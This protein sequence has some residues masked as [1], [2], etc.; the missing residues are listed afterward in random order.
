MT[1]K[2]S[3]KN[4][5]E[6]VSEERRI[7]RELVSL[8]NSLKR[9][10]NTEEANL[11]ISQINSLKISIKNIEKDIAKTLELLLMAKPLRTDNFGGVEEERGKEVR[12]LIQTKF[13]MEK[14]NLL[15]IEKET[16]TRLRGGKKNLVSK[17]V[18]KPSKYVKISNDFFA[19]FSEK[20][21]TRDAFKNLK[22][23]LIKAN[24]QLVPKSYVSLILSTTVLSLIISLFILLFF[25]FFGLGATPPFI[26]QASGS[27]IKRFATIFWIVLVI[28]FFTFI[29]MY[30][31][32][33]MEKKSIANKI[34]REL[35]FATIHM[36]AI[37]GSMIDPSKIF[38]IIIMTGEYKNIEKEFTKIIN[39]INIYG[40]DLVTAL[41]HVSINTSSKRLAE[42][43]NGLTTT[44]TSGG[45][46]PDFFDKRSESLLF[47]YR[48]EEEKQTKA[49]ETFMD[50]YI[51]LVIAAPMILMLLLMMMNISGMGL[52]LDKNA[53]TLIMVLGVTVINFFSLTFLHLKQPSK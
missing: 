40:Y 29:F 51:S 24:I 52:S 15:E 1:G 32:P 10:N 11:I 49:A 39:E 17:K 50:I 46:L 2:D 45:N 30:F 14:L 28:P 13:S 20:L 25:L 18:K 21:I 35:P 5:K 16:L 37:A 8:L 44:I 4:L 47:S 23:D 9:V 36:S 48:L 34:D 26:T 12:P 42:L 38:N 6:K 41:K 43:L 22:R 7:V 53:I 31:Y 19:N 3:I 27:I 33:S